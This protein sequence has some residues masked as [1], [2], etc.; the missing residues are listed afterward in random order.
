[1]TK[2]QKSLELQNKLYSMNWNKASHN[3]WLNQAA[4]IS[5][6]VTHNLMVRGGDVRTGTTVQNNLQLMSDYARMRRQLN[7]KNEAREMGLMIARTKR[8]AQKRGIDIN[9]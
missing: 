1:M 2:Y 3:F 7:L 8:K 5:A 4:A 6:I 9:K